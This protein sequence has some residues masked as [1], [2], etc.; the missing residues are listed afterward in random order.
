MNIGRTWGWTLATLSLG[1]LASL[2]GAQTIITPSSGAQTPPAA[3]SPVVPS[4]GVLNP[5]P[6]QAPSDSSVAVVNGQ[7]ISRAEMEAALRGAGPA[8]QAPE[9][10]RQRQFEVL[11]LLIDNLLLHQF[12]E[13]NT[14][15][16]APQDVEKLLVDMK[17]GLTQQGKTLEE[18][19]HDTNQSPAQLR[20]NLADHL[21]WVK[22]AEGRI[23]EP[24]LQQYY[25]DN[26]DHFDGT[27]VH[28]SHIVLRIPSN[29]TKAE[30]EKAIATL[31]DLREQIAKGN[32]DFAAAAKKYSQDPR[33]AEGGDLGFFPRKWYFDEAFTK[34]AFSLKPDEISDVVATDYGVHLVKVHERKEGK[35]SDYT[36]IKEGVREFC[37]EDMRQQLLDQLR[38]KATIYIP[39]PQ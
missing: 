37:M 4:A 36:K 32:L 34:A 2:S 28:A 16:V 25:R 33:A 22:Y 19:C 8:G 38:K 30:K 5:V 13:Q 27:Q 10:P 15:Q 26:K 17:K 35:P 7:E 24:S 1:G 21:R 18:F 23:T 3:G 11:G 29:A 31:H 9:N 12:L 6:A 39:R 14:P 20:A